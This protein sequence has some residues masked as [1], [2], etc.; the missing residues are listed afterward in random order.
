MQQK[1]RK[2]VDDYIEYVFVSLPNGGTELPQCI[3]CYKTLTND[4][5]RPSRL[6]RNLTAADFALADKP[7]AFFVMKSHSLEKA[8]LDMTEKLEKV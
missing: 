2:H 4:A 6:K 8:E 3:V 5:M 7:K 1:K